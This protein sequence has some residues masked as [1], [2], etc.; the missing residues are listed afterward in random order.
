[1]A[2]F[3]VSFCS[4]DTP[5]VVREI[6]HMTTGLFS[7]YV[8]LPVHNRERRKPDDY[9]T[10][11]AFSFPAVRTYKLPGVAVHIDDGYTTLR[12]GDTYV[13]FKR[14]LSVNPWNLIHSLVRLPDEVFNGYDTTSSVAHGVLCVDTKEQPAVFDEVD[15]KRVIIDAEY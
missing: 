15:V 12:F 5:E 7:V 6:A 1:M 10:M 2:V 11:V 14:D 3:M 8:D 13:I 4:K 9:D